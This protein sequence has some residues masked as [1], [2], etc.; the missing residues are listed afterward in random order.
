MDPLE[1]RMSEYQLSNRH[2]NAHIHTEH[3][4]YTQE[5]AVH[6]QRMLCIH[7]ECCVLTENAVDTQRMLCIPRGDAVYT[8][9]ECCVYSEFCAYTENVVYTQRGWSIWT[10]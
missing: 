9:R 7:R 8:Q 10:P 5:N 6:T 4:V 1:F 3:A 2:F